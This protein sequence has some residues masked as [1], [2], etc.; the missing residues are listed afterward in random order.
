[1]K[2]KVYYTSTKDE[3]KIKIRSIVISRSMLLLCTF[4][5]PAL[6]VRKIGLFERD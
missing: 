5:A 3:G 6:E 1:M 4:G 2:K